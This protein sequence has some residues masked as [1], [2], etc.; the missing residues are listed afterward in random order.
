MNEWQ[1]IHLRTTVTPYVFWL[2]L[3]RLSSKWSRFS[4]DS[5]FTLLLSAVH[6]WWTNDDNFPQYSITFHNMLTDIN[7]AVVWIVSIFSRISNL[8]ESFPVA[9]FNKRV[10]ANVHSS[11]APSSVLLV[12]LV[13]LSSEW[14]Q[15]FLGFSTDITAFW[16]SKL[17]NWPYVSS[18]FIH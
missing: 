13:M 1:Q 3:V 10:A 17:V 12:I 5:Q 14:F 6:R 18:S 4:W 8:H 11:T 7:N 2:I 9:I 16:W 15:F